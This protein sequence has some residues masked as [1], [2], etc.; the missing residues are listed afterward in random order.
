MR[1]NIKYLK[2]EM[3]MQEIIYKLFKIEDITN[4]NIIIKNSKETFNNMFDN[5]EDEFNFYQFVTDNEDFNLFSDKYKLSLIDLKLKNI[6]E[7]HGVN[8]LSYFYLFCSES[9][10]NDEKYMKKLIDID[11]SYL[12]LIKY[13]KTNKKLI[14]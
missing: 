6:I 4:L 8:H 14:Y 5:L 7:N 12:E 2:I 3:L 13:K 1:D 11:S 9:L 10:K